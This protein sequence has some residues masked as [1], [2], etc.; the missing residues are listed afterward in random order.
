MALQLM[1]PADVSVRLDPA[2]HPLEIRLGR[3]RLPV[4]EV[5]SLR[6]EM[7]AYP[8]ARGPREIYVVRTGPV[9]LRLTYHGRERRWRIETLDPSPGW[10]AMARAAA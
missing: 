9:R 2:G 5:E 8:S 6:D 1:A 10:P 4:T 3:E 7:S